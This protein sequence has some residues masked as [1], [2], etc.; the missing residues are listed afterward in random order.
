MAFMFV[1]SEAL[2]RTGALNSWP[3]RLSSIFRK[4]YLAGMALMMLLVA[5]ISAFVNNTPVVAVFIPVVIQISRSA[6]ISPSK[7]LI[8]CH[9]LPFRAPVPSS[10]HQLIFWLRAFW[11]RS[12]WAVSACL[13][14]RLWDWYFSRPVSFIWSLWD[15]GCCRIADRKRT[16]GR[17]SGMRDYLTEMEIPAGS[18]L[19]GSASWMQE[20]FRTGDGYSGSAKGGDSYPVPSGDFCSRAGDVLGQM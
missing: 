14:W 5:V 12:M 18:D 2:L 10:A 9:L 17:N 1:L 3:T 13:T 4:R 19:A 8:H 7:L 16:S 11:R 6:G 20:S 15:S